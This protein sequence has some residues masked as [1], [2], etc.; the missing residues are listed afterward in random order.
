MVTISQYPGTLAI[1][2]TDIMMDYRDFAVVFGGGYVT[3][4]GTLAILIM[5]IKLGYKD[6]LCTILF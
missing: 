2:I 5:D 3:V 6:S 1:L 4:P